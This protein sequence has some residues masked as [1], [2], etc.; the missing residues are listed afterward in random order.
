LEEQEKN[1]A[2]HTVHTSLV[3]LEIAALMR[4]HKDELFLGGGRSFAAKSLQCEVVKGIKAAS[5][6]LP[7]SLQ[8]VA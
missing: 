1:L 4:S 6:T 7:T 5:E 2:M 3:S 8:S